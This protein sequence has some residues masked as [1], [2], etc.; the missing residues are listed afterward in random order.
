MRHGAE[1]CKKVSHCGFDSHP[2]IKKIKLWVKKWVT[3][4][5]SEM[6]VHMIMKQID[7]TILTVEDPELT[8]LLK[9]CHMGLK[10]K[11]TDTLITK[12]Y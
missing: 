3:K 7:L 4:L 12:E 11:T 10:Q 9:L 8:P 6:G 2:D 5:F 1:S